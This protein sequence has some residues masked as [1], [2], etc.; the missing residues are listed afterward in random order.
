M[1]PVTKHVVWHVYVLRPHINMVRFYFFNSFIPPTPSVTSAHTCAHVMP[2]KVTTTRSFDSRDVIHNLSARML[3][4]LD[5]S[6]RVFNLFC[7]AYSAFFCFCSISF[8]LL[9]FLQYFL[10]PS[11]VYAVFPFVFFCLCSISFRLLLF[12][13]YFLSPSFVFAV[14]PFLTMWKPAVTVTTYVSICIILRIL[15]C[16][17]FQ[18]I[19][20]ARRNTSY[21]YQ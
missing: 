11:F 6:I 3:Q 19:R 1:L 13:Q 10:S 7:L 8:R 18:I 14:F 9:L 21:T 16:F 12:L 4:V 17:I 5:A 2:I 20:F 15:H